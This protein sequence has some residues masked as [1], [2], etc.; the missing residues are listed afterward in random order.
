MVSLNKDTYDVHSGSVIAYI[1]NPLYLDNS[2]YRFT[3]IT[4]KSNVNS[5]NISEQTYLQRKNSK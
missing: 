5:R 2:H 3:I 1:Y 4:E